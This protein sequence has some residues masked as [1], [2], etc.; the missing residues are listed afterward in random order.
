MI[1]FTFIILLDLRK[2]INEKPSEYAVMAL[3]FHYDAQSG[4]LQQVKEQI[5]VVVNIPT[6]RHTNCRCTRPGADD[7]AYLIWR[8]INQV[9]S[10][11]ALY[12]VRIKH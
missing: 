3:S 8:E 10:S 11:K 1:S 4:D 9:M 2:S 12:M 5:N 6:S 7:V